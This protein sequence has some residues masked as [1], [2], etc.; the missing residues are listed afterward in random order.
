MR[1][2]I[3]TDNAFRFILTAIRIANE[4]VVQSAGRD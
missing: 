4:D 2:K 3:Q 1:E